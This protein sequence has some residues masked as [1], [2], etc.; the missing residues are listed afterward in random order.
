MYLCAPNSRGK[1]AQIPRILI[2][3]EFPRSRAELWEESGFA[4][5]P[6]SKP[7]FF[8]LS[9]GDSKSI[10]LLL[11]VRISDSIRGGPGT[12]QV[13]KQFS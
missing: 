1:K 4:V 7:H 13:C 8:Y 6:G 5:S 9:K 12:E 10:C 11:G 3:R 2:V